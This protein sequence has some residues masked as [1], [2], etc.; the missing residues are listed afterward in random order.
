MV[1][2]VTSGRSQIWDLVNLRFDV[3]L[4]DVRLRASRSAGCCLVVID[5]RFW[6]PDS[7]NRV[8]K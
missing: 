3:T 5:L 6:Y 1:H 2:F 8:L 4:I 7:V